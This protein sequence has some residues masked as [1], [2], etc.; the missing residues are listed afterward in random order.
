MTVVLFVIAVFV[1]TDYL[2]I[3]RRF[4]M[5]KPGRSYMRKKKKKKKHKTL[6]RKYGNKKTGG[7][8]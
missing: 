2:I 3:S 8:E 5:R 4:A 7:W 1:I 6:Q